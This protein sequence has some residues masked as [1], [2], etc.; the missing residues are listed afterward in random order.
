MSSGIWRLLLVAAFSLLSACATLLVCVCVFAPRRPWELRCHSCF[1]GPTVSQ[2]PPKGR[3]S[4]LSWP[5]FHLTG[6][7]N[8]RGSRCSQPRTKLKVCLQLPA[9]PAPA[10]SLFP[11]RVCFSSTWLGCFFTHDLRRAVSKSPSYVK[12][13]GLPRFARGS[14]L[15]WPALVSSY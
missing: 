14:Q 15:L 8:N 11:P 5:A 10:H 2:P 3:P 1:P 7:I 13:P 9:T 4:L 12:C 6:T